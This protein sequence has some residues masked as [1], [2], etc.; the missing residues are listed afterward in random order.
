[1]DFALLVRVGRITPDY[2]DSGD[3]Q[4]I[5]PPTLLLGTQ[6]EGKL[7]ELRQLLAGLPFRLYGLSDFPNIASVPETGESFS[8]NACLKAAGY[9]AQTSLLTLADD[10]GLEVEA[11]GGGPG[12]LSARYAAEGATDAERT[13]KLLTELSNVPEEKR[14]ARFLSA[15]AIANSRGQIINV[16][17]GVCNGRIDFAP[18]GSGGFGYDPVF[19]PSGYDKSFGELRSEIKN[20]I[21]HRSRALLAAREFLLTLTIRSSD[22]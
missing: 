12:I 19:V 10:S 11:L 22:G 4:V 6:N 1:M 15:V 16:S 3:N 17:V 20:Q 21:S 9:A 18:R 14:S 5:T 8:E 7:R 13:T 2:A